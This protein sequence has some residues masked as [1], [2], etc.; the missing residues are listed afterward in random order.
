M[1]S[2]SVENRFASLAT[3][4][5]PNDFVIIEFGHNDGGSLSST[6]DNGRTDCP[7]AG[8]QTCNT[9]LQK[10]ILTYPA[11]LKNAAA[12]F[13]KLGARVVIASPTP[14]NPW[15]GGKFAYSSPRF[16]TYSNSTAALFEQANF[17]DHG[18]FVANTFQKLG[19]TAVDKFYTKDHTHTSPAGAD[20][21]AKA[22]VKGLLCS[23]SALAGYV[24]NATTSVGG[25]CL[26][27]GSY[28]FA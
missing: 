10:G 14:D 7:G 27:G 24:K 3:L 21:V 15:E 25:S 23:Q 28:N 22:F 13:T 18:T 9:D 16:T 26:K 5:K 20:V 4:L 2:Y 6:A 17:V 19:G 1:R 8:T 11:Y 12:L